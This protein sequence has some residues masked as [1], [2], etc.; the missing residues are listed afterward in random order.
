MASINGIQIKSL[1]S[2]RGHEGEPLYQGNVYYKGK[3]LGFWS[4][5]S[6]GGCDNF[7]FS[8]SLLKDE[9]EK[10][11]NSNMVGDKYRS[12]TNLDILLGDLVNIMETEKTFKKLVKKGCATVVEV[13]DG[14]HGFFVGNGISDKEKAMKALK[15]SIEEYKA[16]C[17]KNEEIKV[18]V[19]QNLSDFDIVI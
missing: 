11:R 6:W 18:N 10:Y 12:F 5:D 2:F 13:T 19:Y 7:D 1:K 15:S 9:V 17:F 3:K 16:K 14:Y 8:E 4:Q